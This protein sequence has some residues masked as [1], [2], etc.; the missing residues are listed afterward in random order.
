MTT[1]NQML[2][3]EITGLKAKTERSIREL[4]SIRIR[5]GCFAGVATP[6]LPVSPEVLSDGQSIWTF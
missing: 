3:E 4:F 5:A 2:G 1:K 6:R